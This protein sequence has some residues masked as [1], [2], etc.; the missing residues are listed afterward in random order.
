MAL[1]LHF[2][3]QPHEEADVIPGVTPSMISGFQLTASR[4]GWR[5]DPYI[6]LTMMIF[7]LTASRRGWRDD[8]TV[9]ANLLNFN[10]Q[11][12][13]EADCSHR[14]C[15]RFYAISTHSLTKRLTY[16]CPLCIKVIIFQLTASRRGWQWLEVQA[17][18]ARNISTHSLTKRLTEYQ[19]EAFTGANTFQLT[20][21]RR[22]WREAGIPYE[23]QKA[24]QLTASRRGWLKTARELD[25]FRYFNS[26]PHEEADN[27]SLQSMETAFKFQLTASRRGW[28]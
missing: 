16:L 4:R 7:Q 10:S 23:V 21:S 6:V 12:H 25:I 28:Q 9:P 3:S 18:F 2:N 8:V 19:D 20:A 5:Y 11:P 27:Y 15:Y 17:R 26:Q 1:W 13:E 14:R 24:F 22:G